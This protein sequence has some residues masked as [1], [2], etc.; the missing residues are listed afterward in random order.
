MYNLGVKHIKNPPGFARPGGIRDPKGL[1]YVVLTSRPGPAGGRHT[2]FRAPYPVQGT[3]PLR[4]DIR[5]A[6]PLVGRI[7]P[8]AAKAGV[9]LFVD[10]A[11]DAHLD[12][13]RTVALADRLVVRAVGQSARCARPS[14]RIRA[15]RPVRPAPPAQNLC[16]GWWLRRCSR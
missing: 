13:H 15:A 7:G 2:L 1:V 14:T 16:S 10:L 11:V 5:L 4:E 9:D 6:H 3:F 12:V 8:F